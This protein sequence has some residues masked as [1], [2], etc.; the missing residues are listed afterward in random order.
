MRTE[1]CLTVVENLNTSWNNIRY[2]NHH[3]TNQGTTATNQQF[4]NSSYVFTSLAR[5]LRWPGRAPGSP[6]P[7]HGNC[8]MKIQCPWIR[9][10]THTVCRESALLE[11]GVAV[12]S[13]LAGLLSCLLGYWLA[14][15]E[16]GE[17]GR[18]VGLWECMLKGRGGDMVGA[19]GG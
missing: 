4:N 15:R 8:T 12:N 16:V 14:V 6:G 1:T 17:V 5:G 18:H 2:M 7:L 13:L 11:R 3:E 10:L 19:C 9:G